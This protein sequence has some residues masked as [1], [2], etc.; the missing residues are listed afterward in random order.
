MKKKAEGLPLTMVVVAALLLLALVVVS[1]IFAGG[2]KR[3]GTNLD[4]NCVQLGGSPP[5]PSGKCDD[6]DK[7]IKVW[8]KEAAGAGTQ[9]QTSKL[10]PC[11]VP[12]GSG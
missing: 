6:S 10:Y 2:M 4:K 1:F 11:C 7:P 9:D 12:L 8:V 3:I 5:E